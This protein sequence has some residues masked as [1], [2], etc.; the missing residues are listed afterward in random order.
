MLRRFAV[1]LTAGLLLSNALP[2]A[3]AEGSL[4]YIGRYTWS[5]P[6]PNFGGFSG[7]EMS[8]DGNALTAVSD[9]GHLIRARII[10]DKSLISGVESQRITPLRNPKGQPLKGARGDAEGL[11]IR[12]DGRIYI[13]F[14]GFHRVWA[15]LDPEGPG[16]WLPRHPDFKFMQ[17]NSSLEA[18]AID[19]S[20]RLYTLP[21]RSGAVDKPFNVYRYDGSWSIPFTL[22]RRGSFLPVGMDFGPDGKLY[23]LERSFS[24]IAFS[25]RI[26]R[27]S[28]SGNRITKEERLLVTS[29]GRHDNLEGISVWTD[30]GGDT[31]IT[32]ISDDNFKFFQRTELVEYA[33]P[34]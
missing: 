18:L 31:R 8:D 10:R 21:E 12:P 27:F 3:E 6:D 15:Y 34:N 16:A 23:L 9:R 7:I 13:S 25:S 19:A 11:A 29:G 26:R 4:R 1:A 22:P 33:L 5:N 28:L 17:N 20:G 24:G 14:E 2:S 32:L 30:A